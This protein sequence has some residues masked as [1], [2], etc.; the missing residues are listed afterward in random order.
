MPVIGLL[1]ETAESGLLTEADVGNLRRLSGLEPGQREVLLMGADAFIASAGSVPRDQAERLLAALDLYGIRRA[2]H[3]IDD[4]D[5]DATSLHRHLRRLSGIDSLRRLLD[6]SFGARAD[7]LKADAACSQLE[8]LVHELP[9]EADRASHVALRD[10][11]EELRLDPVTHALS[12]VRVLR[13]CATDD[14]I[15][16]PPELADDLRRVLTETDL[17]RRVGVDPGA[18]S[19]ELQEAALRGA[20]RWNAFRN[21]GRASPNEARIADVVYRSYSILWE[22][23]ADA[24]AVAAARPSG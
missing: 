21:A 11:L 17:A 6:E 1:A 19:G 14:R 18:P 13:M 22:A 20:A 9:M 16:L 4:Q 10:M 8:R 7:V 2:L 24:P 15:N 12:E 5:A 23:A 3:F